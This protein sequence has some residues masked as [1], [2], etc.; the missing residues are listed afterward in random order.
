MPQASGPQDHSRHWA[1]YDELPQKKQEELDKYWSRQTEDS[2]TVV[3]SMTAEIGAAE[4]TLTELKHMAQ[5]AW[6]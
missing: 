1:Q 3:T 2:T 4:M 6:T 5:S